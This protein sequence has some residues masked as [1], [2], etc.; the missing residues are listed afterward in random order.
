MTYQRS[1]TRSINQLSLSSSPSLFIRHISSRWSYLACSGSICTLP[2]QRWSFWA[3]SEWV[4]T[5]CRGQPVVGR[6]QRGS[7]RTGW[8]RSSS[9]GHVPVSQ[10]P[11]HCQLL[12]AQI[13]LRTEEL[14]CDRRLETSAAR[15]H[16]DQYRSTS[17]SNWWR[18]PSAATVATKWS[19]WR[20]IVLDPSLN[21]YNK[22]TKSN[23]HRSIS[24]H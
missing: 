7:I 18:C 15:R 10:W 12:P 6:W 1:I 2:C 20:R 17:R 4:W 16:C 22:R 19:T 8:W 14:A 13:W 9:D 23:F 3:V 11:A 5:A 21:K 24:N